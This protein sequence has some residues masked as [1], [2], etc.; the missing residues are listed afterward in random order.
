MAE[1]EEF[2]HAEHAEDGFQAREA[3]AREADVDFD[4]AP[5]D[6]FAEV[7][8]R[9]ALGRDGDLQEDDEAHE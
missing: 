6:D 2:V 3:R 1:G 9:V 5:D 7:V 4:D 8:C